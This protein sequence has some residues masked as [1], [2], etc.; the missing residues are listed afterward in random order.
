VDDAVHGV[1]PGAV[2]AALDHD[3]AY[4]RLEE[5]LDAV[6]PV[7]HQGEFVGGEEDVDVGQQ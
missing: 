6:G 2:G 4:A 1:G 5:A 7:G 3:L